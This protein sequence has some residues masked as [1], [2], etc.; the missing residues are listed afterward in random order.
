MSM[1]AGTCAF[2]KMSPL[3]SK[4]SKRVLSIPMLKSSSQGVTKEALTIFNKYVF[5][6]T[7]S[8]IKLSIKP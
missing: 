3:I 8:S 1:G 6:M 2:H 7:I 5:P 4:D